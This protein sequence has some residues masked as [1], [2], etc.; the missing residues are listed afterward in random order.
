LDESFAEL[1]SIA[2]SE[3]KLPIKGKGIVQIYLDS[4]HGTTILQVKDV[5]YSPTVRINLLSPSVIFQRSGIWGQWSDSIIL[6]DRSNTPFGEAVYVNGLWR[7]ETTNTSSKKRPRVL[8]GAIPPEINAVTTNRPNQLTLWHR[9][10]GHLNTASVKDLVKHVI[11]MDLEDQSED[12][13]ICESCYLGKAIKK[14]SG[15]S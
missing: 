2:D 10:L 3:K 13:N 4:K 9:R 15:E 12:M 6:Y 8:P 7:L 1:A 11:G 5:Y 14:I